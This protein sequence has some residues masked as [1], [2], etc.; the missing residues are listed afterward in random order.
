MNITIITNVFPYPL[1]SG[2]AQAQFNM[3][4]V[5]CKKHN[6]SI[7]FTED[8]S[9]RLSAMR[10]LKQMWPEVR[11]FPFRYVRQMCYPLF[12][13]DKAVRAFKLKFM[14][15]NPR[16]QVERALKPYGVYFSRDFSAF[17]N[18]IVRETRA[19]IVQA[20]FFPCLGAVECL[21]S[22][23]K[24]V[25]IH[26]EIRFVRNRRL[27]SNIKMTE[28]EQRQEKEVK[29]LEISRLN[30][31]DAVVTLTATDKKIL[32]QNGVTVPVFV[33]P[34]AVNAKKLT[35]KE[36]NGNI[37]FIGGYGHL[38]HKEGIDWFISKVMKNVGR[39]ISL[40]IIGAGWPQS[41]ERD[42][43]NVKLLGFVE[44]LE[45]VAPGSIMIVPILTGSG[46]R[47]KILEAAAMNI[48]FVTT[49]VGVE[50]LDFK[51]EDSCLVA[52]TPNDF[53]KALNRLTVDGELRRFIAHNASDLWECMY[54]VKSLSKVRDDI[55]SRIC[56]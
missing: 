45:D 27:L 47:M 5:L 22:N 51:N 30:K 10:S 8:G 26:H 56:T 48:P 2:G 9:N 23:V 37:I 12:L 28:Q 32:G 55:Y 29:E 13:K 6:I 18:K 17:I 25:F 36:W 11:F 43:K 40:Q 4:D 42:N 19:D 38:P 50:G 21:P 20:E 16:F 46:M 41:Y 1:N 39:N 3:I 15:D 52:D 24:K 31:Y 49:S 33:S 35:Y 34:A 7:I 44:R 14:Y 53:A 54:S